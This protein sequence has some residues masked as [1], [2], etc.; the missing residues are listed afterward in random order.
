MVGF[1]DGYYYSRSSNLML[2]FNL[3]EKILDLITC[4]D[5]KQ[6]KMQ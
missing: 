3:G 1:V 5:L 4:Q 2:L 6:V